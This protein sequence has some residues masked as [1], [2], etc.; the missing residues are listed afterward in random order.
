VWKKICGK[1]SHAISFRDFLV[2]ERFRFICS[3]ESFRP[4]KSDVKFALALRLLKRAERAPFLLAGS[5]KQASEQAECVA[6]A[7]RSRG[8]SLTFGGRKRS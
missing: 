5:G 4:P 7:V 6:A 8:Y 1:G 3:S 2:R